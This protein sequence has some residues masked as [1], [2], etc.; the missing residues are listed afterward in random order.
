[1]TMQKA[2]IL[3]V[4]DEPR[5]LDF[6]RVTLEATGFGVLE[7]VDGQEALER[8]REGLAD[9]V[10]L[11]VGLPEMDGFETLKLIREIS[12]VPVIMVTVRSDE[13]DKIRGLELGADDYV[14]KP[15]SPGELGARIKAVLR[16]AEMSSVTDGMLTIDEHLS[17]DFDEREVIVDGERVPL[18]PTEYRL[19]YQL[20]QNAGRTLPYETLLARVWGHEYRDEIHY[21]HLYVTYLRQKIEPDP[22]NPK[23]ILTKR[24]VGYSFRPLEQR[25]Q[26]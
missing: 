20:I 23:Y 6:I 25:R 4:D 2:M 22:Q 15:F 8:V 24:G 9:L 17:V 16:R 12:R 5:M 3:A 26:G 18:R 1:M 10:L 11:D 21:V 7:A 14:T 19:L 13:R